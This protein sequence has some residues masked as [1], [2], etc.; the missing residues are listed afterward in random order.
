LKAISDEFENWLV[1]VMVESGQQKFETLIAKLRGLDEQLRK[2][3]EAL[4][5]KAKEYRPTFAIRGVIREYDGI[6]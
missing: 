3:M 4:R 1:M 6:I 2:R 5:E